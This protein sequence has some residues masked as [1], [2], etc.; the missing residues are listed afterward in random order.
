[1]L[2]K[3]MVLWLEKAQR[4]Y[5]KRSAQA[6]DNADTLEPDIVGEAIAIGRVIFAADQRR[7]VGAARAALPRL[8]GERILP[9]R[10][11]QPLLRGGHRGEQAEVDAAIGGGV[12]GKFEA[13]GIVL[14]VEVD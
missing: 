7:Q 2:L 13:R 6:F 5:H 3:N 8:A 14:G 11:M 12:F 1:M 4:L 10:L 9:G